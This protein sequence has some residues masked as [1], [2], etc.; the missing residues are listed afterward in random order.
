MYKLYVYSS[1]IKVMDIL[2]FI[3]NR[4]HYVHNIISITAYLLF[5]VWGDYFDV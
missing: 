1:K 3:S 4:F 5:F 2:S